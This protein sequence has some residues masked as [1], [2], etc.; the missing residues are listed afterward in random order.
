[1]FFRHAALLGALIFTVA[2]PARSQTTRDTVKLDGLVVHLHRPAAGHRTAA[3]ILLGGSGGGI[4]WQNYM[5]ELLAARGIAAMAV[6][7]FGMEGLPRE[8]ERIPLE[9][10][11]HAFKWLAAQP[12]IDPKRIGIAGVSKG[13]ELALLLASMHPDLKAVGVFVPSTVVFQSIAAGFPRTSS[14]TLDGREVP[15]VRYGNVPQGAALSEIYTAGINGT[16]ADSLE[17]ATIKVERIR[18]PI[19]MLSG[20]S[21]NLWPSAMLAEMAA[22]RLRGKKFAFPV[23]HIA[24]ENAGHLISSIRDDDVTRRGGTKE[25]NEFAQ[26]DGQSRFLDF[27]AR[28]LRP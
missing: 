28:S 15:F 22:A 2:T 23:E 21:D 9:R 25:G 19:L 10:F 11:D 8:L 16:A 14:W 3:V 20:K 4:G 17:A 12:S 18:G 13:A 26:H 1:M 5:G 6:G 27:F 7:Y 24:Y